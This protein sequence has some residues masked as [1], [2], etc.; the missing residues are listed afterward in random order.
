MSKQLN[1][2][3]NTSNFSQRLIIVMSIATLIAVVCEAIW[4]P[5]N[6]LNVIVPTFGFAVAITGIISNWKQSADNGVAQQVTAEKV[7][8]IKEKVAIVEE[9]TLET[10]VAVAQISTLATETQ[11]QV[12]ENTEIT[13]KT[14]Q[15]VNSQMDAFK[16]AMQQ[17]IT[18]LKAELAAVIEKQQAKDEGIE[19][20]RAQAQLETPQ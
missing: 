1:A 6:S 10:A 8:T 3:N 19:I 14:H 2:T 5:E 4:I 13:D 17:Q 7:E 18:D 20:G 11:S 9:K 16:S 12:V 15:A